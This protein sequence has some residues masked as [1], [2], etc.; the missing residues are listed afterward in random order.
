MFLESRSALAGP[1]LA[2]EHFMNSP[3]ISRSMVKSR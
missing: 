3:R 2:S 1:Q